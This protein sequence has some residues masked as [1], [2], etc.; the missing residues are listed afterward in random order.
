[1]YCNFLTKKLTQWYNEKCGKT[2][3]QFTFRFRGKESLCYF[4]YFPELCLLMLQNIKSDV[5]SEQVLQVFHCSILLRR[6]TSY[7][8]RIE[9]FESSMLAELSSDCLKLFKSC[10]IFFKRISPSLWTYCQIAP[11]HC[12]DTFSSYGYGLGCN[13]MEGR[14]QKHQVIAQYA[15]NTTVKNRWRQIFRHEFIHLIHLRENGFDQKKYCKTKNR[16]IPEPTDT[17]CKNCS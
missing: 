10:C 13:T 9:D 14:E 11:V 2:G 8:V 5:V 6:I 7:I 16:Y 15:H 4:K 3:E 1:M 12:E 17:S